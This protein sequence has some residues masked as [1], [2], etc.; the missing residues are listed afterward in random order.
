MGWAWCTW[1]WIIDHATI[2]AAVISA[3]AAAIIAWFTVTLAGATRGLL[4]ATA[5]QARLT[6]KSI[7]LARKEF[8]AT[9]RPKIIIHSAAPLFETSTEGETLGATITYYNAGDADA[10][11]K[12]I[13]CLIAQQPFGV[14]PNWVIPEM[15]DA[16]PNAPIKSGTGQIFFFNSNIRAAEGEMGLQAYCVGRIEYLDKAGLKR[17]TGFIR[18]YGSRRWNRLE[19]DPNGYE[20][21]Y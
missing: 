14:K 21:A 7:N 5:D 10:D 1:G 11:I 17:E 9:H 12:T 2:L 20:Y 3:I 8:N 15:P 4:K 19:D 6:K 18:V 13:R 16:L